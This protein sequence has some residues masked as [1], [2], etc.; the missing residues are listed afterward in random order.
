MEITWW[1]WLV[2]GLLLVVAEMATPGGFYILF[3]GVGA[4]VVGSL[5]G[6]ELAGPL[7]V[8]VVLFAVISVILLVVFRTRLLEITQ[9]DPQMPPVDTLVGEIAVAAANILPDAVGTVEL[10]G[11]TWSARNASVGAIG[12]GTRCVVRRVDGL[13]V[14]VEPEGGR[15]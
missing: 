6:F 15:S 9:V 5:A 3:F 8:Q 13:M 11:T 10:R 1:H 14:Y 12:A 7:W 2:L 4:L